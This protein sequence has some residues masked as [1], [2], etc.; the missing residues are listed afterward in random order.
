MTCNA[1][2]IHYPHVEQFLVELLYA[3][4][5]HSYLDR[6][7]LLRSRA[8]GSLTFGQ[9]SIGPTAL[10]KYESDRTSP[11]YGTFVA[12]CSQIIS[13]RLGGRR[14]CPHRRIPRRTLSISS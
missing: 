1:G 13:V 10:L 9:P 3:L 14:A 11:M 2:I 12:N 4:L 5:K 7:S 8:L 6:P